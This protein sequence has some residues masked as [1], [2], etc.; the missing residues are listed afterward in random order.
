MDIEPFDEIIPMPEGGGGCR[1]AER[2]W[3]GGIAPHPEVLGA[4]VFFVC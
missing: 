2:G 4:P 1:A 3:Q